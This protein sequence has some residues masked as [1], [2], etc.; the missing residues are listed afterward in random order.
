MAYS[1]KSNVEAREH[2]R[3]SVPAMYTLIRVRAKGEK[4]YQHTGY[5]YDISPNGIRFELDD[6]IAPGS[7]I[8][9]RAMLPGHD[10]ITFRATGQVVRIH[11]DLDEPGPLRMAMHIDRFHSEIDCQKLND[12]LNHRRAIKQAA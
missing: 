6:P 9:I 11:D 3:A 10:T 2:D 12:Y 8:E 4:N 5:I 7:D 1:F